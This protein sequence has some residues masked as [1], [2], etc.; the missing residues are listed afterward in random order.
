MTTQAA[1]PRLVGTAFPASASI[2]RSGDRAQEERPTVFSRASTRSSHSGSNSGS[3]GV[4][5]QKPAATDPIRSVR[6]ETS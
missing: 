1:Q 4:A 6:L 5:C 2:Q 3:H